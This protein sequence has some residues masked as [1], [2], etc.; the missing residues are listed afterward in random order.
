MAAAVR[1]SKASGPAWVTKLKTW[2]IVAAFLVAAG[3][4]GSLTL[5]AAGELERNYGIIAGYFGFARVVSVSDSIEDLK[6]W[7][8]YSDIRRI[9]N[10][11]GRAQRDSREEQVVELSDQLAEYKNEYDRL[12]RKRHTGGRP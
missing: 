5:G 1:R 2:Q 4:L 3:T 10:E 7:Q 9:K 12:R 8:L 11:I 6:M